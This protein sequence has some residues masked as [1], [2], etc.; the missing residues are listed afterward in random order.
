MAQRH[1]RRASA[2]FV[3]G[4]TSRR[5]WIERHAARESAGSCMSSRYAASDSPPCVTR[6]H[7]LRLRSGAE[8]AATA[9]QRSSQ[10]PSSSLTAVG[11]GATGRSAASAAWRIAAAAAADGNARAAQNARL[12][13]K[14]ARRP[15]PSEVSE[16]HSLDAGP[17]LGGCDTRAS[18][19]LPCSSETAG[20]VRSARVGHQL[21]C[22]ARGRPTHQSSTIECRSRR[23]ARTRSTT[24][25]PRVAPATRRSRT[26]WS[27]GSCPCGRKR[28]RVG[29]GRKG[30]ALRPATGWW[31]RKS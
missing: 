11:A 23:A 4:P 31:L 10:G 12:P 8:T 28:R 14:L 9:A 21:G 6:C 27:S 22:A 3:N 17:R 30:T 24:C 20:A 16:R 13:T 25:R 15:T 2:R 5:Q 19:R 7:R 1:D 29:A 26:A 18:T